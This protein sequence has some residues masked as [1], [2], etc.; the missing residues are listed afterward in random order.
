MFVHFFYI[1]CREIQQYF[2]TRMSSRVRHKLK[3][4]FVSD[5]NLYYNGKFLV[6]KYKI[7]SPSIPIKISLL[8]VFLCVHLYPHKGVH[9]KIQWPKYVC[10]LTI[11]IWC[12]NINSKYIFLLISFK[13]MNYSS[14]ILISCIVYLF[15]FNFC[16]LN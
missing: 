8:L 13:N 16:L 9:S 2:S 14:K 5:L 12:P 10:I 15:C 7:T 1:Y 6:Q 11:L 3:A 4:V